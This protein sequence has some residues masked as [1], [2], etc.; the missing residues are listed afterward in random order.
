MTM[1][2]GVCDDGKRGREQCGGTHS[3]YG[4][5]WSVRPGTHSGYACGQRFRSVQTYKQTTKLAI[6]QTNEINSLDVRTAI[7]MQVAH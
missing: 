7:L 2:N 4:C 5:R 3:D 1:D 6:E